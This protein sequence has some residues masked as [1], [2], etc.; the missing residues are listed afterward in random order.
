MTFS[1]LLLG[2][3]KWAEHGA[4]NCDFARYRDDTSDVA[5]VVFTVTAIQYNVGGVGSC[6][7]EHTFYCLAVQV[8]LIK[9]YT[10]ER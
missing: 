2:W 6:R 4:Y 10:I 5:V 9:C 7:Q 3:V 8:R 1:L